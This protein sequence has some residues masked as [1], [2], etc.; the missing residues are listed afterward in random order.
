MQ[1]KILWR[2]VLIVIFLIA[3]I[4]TLYPTFN[5]GPTQKEVDRL[6]GE[7]SQITGKSNEMVQ[8]TICS[9]IQPGVKSPNET[10]SREEQKNRLET[11]LRGRLR[12]QL[13]ISDQGQ[14]EKYL[15][16]A[17]ALRENYQTYLKHEGKAIKLGLDLQGGTY[18][19]SE[20]N[21]PKH[22]YNLAKDK[23]IFDPIYNEA[24]A[25]YSTL[26]GDF[27]N[28]LSEKIQQHNFSL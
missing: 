21:I 10:L 23:E 3:A 14:V 20:V 6:I 11:D 13:G 4:F 22:I 19:V 26:K 24:L 12:K 8:S 15:P 17:I 9:D 7:L 2:S 16:T 27:L 5:V 1:R 18:L 25:E 28:I